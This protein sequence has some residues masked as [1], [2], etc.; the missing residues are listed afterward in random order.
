MSFYSDMEGWET[1][2]LL[3]CHH[4]CQQPA[5]E[6]PALRCLLKGARCLLLQGGTTAHGLGPLPHRFLGTAPAWRKALPAQEAQ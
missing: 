5:R 2:V 4:L 3:T 6:M 1:D